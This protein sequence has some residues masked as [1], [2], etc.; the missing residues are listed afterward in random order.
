[1]EARV[2]IWR[3][4]G[5]RTGTEARTEGRVEGRERLRTYEII[6]ET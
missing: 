1:M 2:G 5:T 6:V 3:A 4:A